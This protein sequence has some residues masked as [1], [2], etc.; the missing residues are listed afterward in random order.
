MENLYTEGGELQYLD[1]GDYIGPYHVML[2]G[3]PFSGGAH[4]EDSEA[5]EFIGG[6]IETN[7]ISDFSG[8][9][10]DGFKL[11][12]QTI[13]PSFQEPSAFDLTTDRIELAIYDSE[14]RILRFEQ[15]YGGYTIE[16]AQSPGEN[17]VNE[18]YINPVKDT[19]YSGYYGQ[20]KLALIYN[21][22]KS[23][24]NNITI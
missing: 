14:Q 9:F 17:S 22:I 10:S 6:N 16:N 19:F 23:D 2:N 13:I 4:S 21:F 24:I 11:R 12:D 1:G 3:V 15:N 7:P 20:S 5:L 18:I 8:Y